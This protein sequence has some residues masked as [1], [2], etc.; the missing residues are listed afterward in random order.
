[1][2][3]RQRGNLTFSKLCI[4][5]LDTLI[6]AF[7]FRER[8][9]CQKIGVVSQKPHTEKWKEEHEIDILLYKPRI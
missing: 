7:H 8:K 6:L 2:A 9:P 3:A 4:S 1:L 5:E